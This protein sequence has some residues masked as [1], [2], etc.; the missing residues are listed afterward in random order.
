MHFLVLIAGLTLGE[1]SGSEPRTD[2]PQSQATV[3]PRPS[4]LTEEIQKVLEV[5]PEPEQ[6]IVVP[7]SDPLCENAQARMHEVFIA[8]CDP[9]FDA[10]LKGPTDKVSVALEGPTGKKLSASIE[11]RWGRVVKYCPQEV[12]LTLAREYVKW[13]TKLNRSPPAYAAAFLESAGHCNSAKAAITG[14]AL[15]DGFREVESVCDKSTVKELAREHFRKAEKQGDYTL[16]IRLAELGELPA[17]VKRLQAAVERQAAAATAHKAR[18]AQRLQA[19]AERQNAARA[20]T[21]NQEARRLKEEAERRNAA[22]AAQKRRF[23]EQIRKSDSYANLLED[24]GMRELFTEFPRLKDPF[25]NQKK[26]KTSVDDPAVLSNVLH[27]IQKILVQLPGTYQGLFREVN[28]Y[29]SRGEND[30]HALCAWE[31]SAACYE[32]GRD[33]IYIQV[34]PPGTVPASDITHELAH[35]AVSH[36]PVVQRGILMA[37]LM[38]PLASLDLQKDVVRDSGGHVKSWK[39]GKGGP[40]Y[41]CVRAYGA[42]NSDE[43]LATYVE[44]ALANNGQ[45]IIKVLQGA[46]RNDAIRTLEALGAAG[47]LEKELIQELYRRAG[48]GHEAIQRQ[49]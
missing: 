33:T 12:T 10:L 18:E 24:Q 17:E 29:V 15:I 28:T 6:P 36:L 16:A 23:A 25:F 22:R 5:N 46:Y 45:D 38:I 42:T 41:A 27:A 4:G 21:R 44:D 8:S 9:V 31:S 48:L 14:G 2:M 19:E 26:L 7:T 37:Q 1:T 39:D 47:I 43:F 20:A 13:S 35:A 49:L 11:R 34:R 40:R 3:K 32:S 30:L